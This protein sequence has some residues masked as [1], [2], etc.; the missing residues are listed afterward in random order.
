M[1]KKGYTFIIIYLIIAVCGIAVYIIEVWHDFYY[2]PRKEILNEMLYFPSGKFLKIIVCD[3]DILFSNIVWLRAIQYYGQHALTDY[4]YPWLSHIFDI[5]T[6]LDPYF[7]NG[8]RFGGI[9][10]SEDGGKPEEAIKLLKRALDYRPETWEPLFDIGFI[11][12]MIIK[13]YNKAAR[14]FKLASLN[15]GYNGRSIRFAAHSLRKAKRYSLAKEMWEIVL[16]NAQHEKRKDTAIRSI[17]YIQIDADIDTLQKLANKYKKVYGRYPSN[18]LELKE[19]Y[20]IN[21]IPA[22][23]F[24]GRYLITDDGIVMSTTLLNDELELKVRFLN[25]RI[26]AYK[27]AKGKYP[28]KL[29]DLVKEGFLVEIPSHPFDEM[30]IY[31]KVKGEVLMPG[32]GQ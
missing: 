21:E 7:I 13:D 30:Y 8:Y 22:E 27:I 31:D 11:Y 32:G 18:I 3:F 12:N 2:P 1:K 5:L 20:L 4:H 25:Q 29:G 14:Y 9:L 6:Q 10:I 26:K 24:G 17:R 16:K 28:D 15:E 19:A 23:P